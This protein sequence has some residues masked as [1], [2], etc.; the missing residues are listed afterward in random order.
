MAK[1]TTE[2]VC[3]ECG[4][5]HLKY[6]GK[7]KYCEKWNS[8]EEQLIQEEVKSSNNR[9]SK[10]FTKISSKIENLSEVEGEEYHRIETKITEFDRVLG[11][12]LVKGSVILLG[13]DPGIGKSTLLLQTITNL[14]KNKSKVLYISGEESAHQISMRAKRLNLNVDN[15]RIYSEIEFEKIENA[16]KEEESDF[17]II[18]SIQTLFSSQLSSA[19]GSISQI[20]ECSSQL[21]RIAKETNTTMLIICHVTKDGELAGPR[22]LEHI[23]DTVL[24]FEGDKNNQYRMIRAFKNRFGPINEIGIFSMTEKGLVVVEDPTGVF[25]NSGKK[26]P[27]AAIYVTQ[28]GNR[29][30]MVEIQALLDKTPLPNPIRRSIGFDTNRLQML[31]AI[32][33][34]Y[35]DLP[36]YTQNV[37]VT[38]IGG[39]KFSDTGIDLPAFLAMI[40]SYQNK[41]LS[42]SLV[43]FGEIGLTGELRTVQNTEDRIKEAA[44]MGI[45]KIVIPKATGKNNIAQLKKDLNVEIIQCSDL[46]EVVASVF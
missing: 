23:V 17:V 43:S 1:K 14:S 31:C 40:S 27:G 35:I 13:G 22:A 37:F 33:N 32:I 41:P 4:G 28:E 38:L 45:K 25:A 16:L 39:M 11:G 30:I 42:E 34:K 26:L 46:N 10:T 29:S 20:K 24:Y 2:W 7:C 6:Q 5:T 21:A 19:P 44:R 8:L 18:D 15:V 36:I 3:K 9:Y 12:G